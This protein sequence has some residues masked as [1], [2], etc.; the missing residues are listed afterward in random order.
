MKKI[1]AF[2]KETSESFLPLGPHE[3]PA[4]WKIVVYE[5]ESKFL[6]DSE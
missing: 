1:S 3:H 2:I 4:R 6:R 5:P